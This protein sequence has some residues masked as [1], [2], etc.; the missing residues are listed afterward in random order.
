MDSQIDRLIGKV[1]HRLKT[2]RIKLTL[3]RR[4]DWLWAR[5]TL[6]AKPHLV[7]KH[8]Q[9]Y[10]QRFPL[11]CPATTSGISQA[12]QLCR[13]A[14]SK[15]ALGQFNWAD[16][17]NLPCDTPTT[18]QGWIERF[19]RDYWRTHGTGPSARNNWKVYAQVFAQ[20][21]P[22]GLL[23]QDLLIEVL[24]RVEVDTRARQKAAQV[25]VQLAAIAGLP[26]TAIASLRGDYS[27]DSVEPRDLPSDPL[28]A[29]IY[30]SIQNPAWRWVYGM[31]ATY[32]LR[33]HEVFH[34]DL[35]DFPTVWVEDQTKTGKRFVY[36]LYRDWA[37]R[38]QLNYRQLP[39][40]KELEKPDKYQWDNSALGRKITKRFAEMNVGFTPYAL[41]HSYSR[42][43]F[44]HKMSA[45]VMAK[46][47]GHSLQVQLKVYRA[48]WDE[49][50]YKRQYESVQHLPAP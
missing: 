50:T 47:M 9:P 33:N 18:V 43:G 7:E 39:R 15:L 49:S 4:G 41:R 38:W 40:L 17:V 42:R 44:E 13:L 34:V 23:T 5:G 36:P 14:A 31:M 24:A 12:E 8:P 10:Q 45:E 27:P 28:I 35:A 29:E 32:G 2:A 6:P 1:N 11:D 48:W 26:T 19:E 16:W 25:L 37:V 46:L 20:L 3:E 21:P 22:Q 30:A